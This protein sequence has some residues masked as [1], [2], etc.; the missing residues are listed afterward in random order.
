MRRGTAEAS[1]KR[2]WNEWSKI[3]QCVQRGDIAEIQHLD[4]AYV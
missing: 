4:G 1:F 3:P 2:V